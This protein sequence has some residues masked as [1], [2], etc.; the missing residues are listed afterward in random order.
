MSKRFAVLMKLKK[1]V[2][3]EEVHQ[4]AELLRKIGDPD[5][6]TVSERTARWFKTLKPGSKEDVASE[7]RGGG[8]ITEYDDE[9]GDPTFYIP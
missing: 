9:H 5:W 2:S 1:G 4:L 7:G 8:I 3:Q 6:T